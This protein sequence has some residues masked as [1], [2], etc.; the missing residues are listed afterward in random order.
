MSERPERWFL[1]VWPD[2]RVRDALVRQASGAVPR[3]A[4][5]THPDDLHLTLVFLG[6]LPPVRRWCVISVADA[7]EAK[8]FALEIDRIGH[9]AR[10]R[11]LWC[12]PS[13]V[14]DALLGLVRTLQAGLVDCGI[15]PERRPYRPHLTLARKVSAYEGRDL[16]APVH[17]PVGELVLAHGVSGARPRYRIHRRWPLSGP[18]G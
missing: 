2:A 1:A 5:L 3:G 9:F 4:R 14:P 6:E 15:P 11:V 17:W 16:P 7:V 13:S 12:G 10:S 8:P 18:G